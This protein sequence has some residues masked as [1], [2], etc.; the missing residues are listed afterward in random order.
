MYEFSHVT[1]QDAAYALQL[2]DRRRQL[3]LRCARLMETRFDSTLSQ[4]IGQHYM[5]SSEPWRAYAFFLRAAELLDFRGG[6]V[7]CS[8]LVNLQTLDT[9]PSCGMTLEGDD[10]AW[11][12]RA[13]LRLLLFQSQIRNAFSD[14][15]A[16]PGIVEESVVFWRQLKRKPPSL[17]TSIRYCS[18]MCRLRFISGM[19]LNRL[20][21]GDGEEAFSTYYES[22][23][24]RFYHD[25]HPDPA[26]KDEAAAHLLKYCRWKETGICVDAELPVE[27]DTRRDDDDVMLRKTIVQLCL[28][29]PNIGQ[30][31]IALYGFDDS[32]GACASCYMYFLE[33]NNVIEMSRVIRHWNDRP[34][35]THDLSRIRRSLFFFLLKWWDMDVAALQ[36]WADA[37]FEPEQ[38]VQLLSQF[39]NSGRDP[40]MNGKPNPNRNRNPSPNPN[41]LP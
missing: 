20:S 26:R 7:V 24:N 30:Q 1:L 23:C 29:H 21:E 13:Q 2:H 17:S 3:H 6:H 33:S 41:P 4:D 39:I 5:K 9:L 11:E 12:A 34:E 15:T 10:D 14:R 40:A 37:E 22:V 28:D 19:S 31:I 32:W 36:Q 25:F 35:P 18:L 16:V 27:E 38:S 8:F